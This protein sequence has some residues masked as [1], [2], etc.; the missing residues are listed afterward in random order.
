MHTGCEHIH[1]HALTARSE[2]KQLAGTYVSSWR[3]E[4][5]RLHFGRLQSQS[6]RHMCVCVCVCVC[7]I[8]IYIYIYIHTHKRIHLRIHAGMH[9]DCGRHDR[10]D[11]GSRL[12]SGRN[13][14]SL[15]AQIL[16]V[17]ERVS[18]YAILSKTPHHCCLNAH[19][20]RHL[21]SHDTLTTCSQICAARQNAKPIVYVHKTLNHQ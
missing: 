7:I 12:R 21:C 16:H 5:R 2:T 17:L 20:C 14:F 9:T 1:I 10:R 18:C 4:R 3:Q 6:H 8:Y 15:D 11:A 13:Q 19:H